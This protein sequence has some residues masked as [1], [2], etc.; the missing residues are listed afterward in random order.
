MLRML[1]EDPVITAVSF[2]VHP[3]WGGYDYVSDGWY[4]RRG[5]MNVSSPVQM[6][7]GVPLRHASAA[8]VADEVDVDLRERRWICGE[9][10]ARRG[11]RLYH[12][13]HV[14]PH[15]VRNK[16]QFYRHQAPKVCAEILEWADAGF[17]TLRR[18]YHVERH[19]WLPAWIQ[20]Y[21]GPHPPEALRML[22]DIRPA[23][24]NVELRRID[25]VERLFRRHATGWG[26]RCLGTR[27]CR[28]GEALV[29]AA[30]G[31]RLAC[32]VEG[33]HAGACAPTRS[34]S[35]APARRGGLRQR[36]RDMRVLVTGGAGF[37]G[38]NIVGS[39]CE[40]GH[41]V[42]VL[43]DLLERLSRRT[44]FPACRSSRATSATRRPST[45]SHGGVRGRA[46]IWP[47]ASATRVP[48]RTRSTIRQINVI[49]TLNVLEAARRQG[50][51][52]VVFS[53]SAGIF[54]ELKTLPIRE[55]HP[56]EPDSPYGA[57][58]LAAEKLCLA[59]DKLYGMRE[60]VPALLQR[61]RRQPALR[62]LRQRDPD[63]RPPH[64]AWQPLTIFGDGEQTRDF[65]NVRDVAAGQHRGR[66]Q[67]RRRRG[68]Q[69]RQRHA[70]DDQRPGGPHAACRA[71]WRPPSSTAAAPGRRARQPGGRR[72]RPR[73]VRLSS[74]PSV[75]RTA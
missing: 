16:A 2:N 59:Y 39:S 13:D 5:H 53:S 21:G 22:D 36:G 68:L 43:D 65:V 63:L 14:F 33:R 7:A 75:S 38:S 45:G 48:S 15:Q 3:F 1:S 4:W 57:S 8:H 44:S 58:K 20:R 9:E 69:H 26:S 35:A 10:M 40:Q 29:G 54:G 31:P 11:V 18:P 41:E 52:G 74:R 72:R 37:I 64:A 24:L 56:A 6:G 61:L 42:V 73:G 51:G 66:G 62:R 70:G 30:D 34:R 19:Y 67:R 23:K 47:R 25:D 27:L 12:Y 49:G 17:F 55:D 60:R 71:A 46:S 32:A 28:Q 50:V